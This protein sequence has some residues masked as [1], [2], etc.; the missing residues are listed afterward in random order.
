MW[1]LFPP[2]LDCT[3]HFLKFVVEVKASIPPHFLK[4][5]I[6]LNKGI[7]SMQ[8]FAQIILILVAVKF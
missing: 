3:S 5:L 8:T 6:A 7:L 1:H 4:L 2:G